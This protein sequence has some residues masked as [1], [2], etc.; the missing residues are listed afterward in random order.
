MAYLRALQVI[1]ILQNWIK[2]RYNQLSIFFNVAYRCI[3]GTIFIFVRFISINY[4]VTC[5]FLLSF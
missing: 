1:L 3:V 5:T 4:F 2:M